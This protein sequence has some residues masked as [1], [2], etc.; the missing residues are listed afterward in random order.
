MYRILLIS[1]IVMVCLGATLCIAQ[2]WLNIVPWDI[3]FK[4]IITLG[5]LIVLAGL[6][7]VIKTD[8]SQH[9]KMKDENYLD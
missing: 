1:V 6:V 5:I 8:L 2:L 3:F 4:T 7:L 9:K